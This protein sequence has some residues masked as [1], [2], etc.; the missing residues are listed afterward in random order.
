VLAILQ[1]YE[2]PIDEQLSRAG[3]RY[4]HLVGK[5]VVESEVIPSYIQTKALKNFQVT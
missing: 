1:Q 2:N 5:E 4:I 3:L